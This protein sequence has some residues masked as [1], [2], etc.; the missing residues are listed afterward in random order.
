MTEEVFSGSTIRITADNIAVCRSWLAQL[1]KEEKRLRQFLIEDPRRAVF[2][3]DSIFYP[4][5]TRERISEFVAILDERIRVLKMPR[6]SY[7][8]G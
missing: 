6:H 3:G 8:T 2:D 1:L 7:V 4:L 5:D